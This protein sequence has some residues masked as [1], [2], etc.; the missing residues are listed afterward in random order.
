MSPRPVVMHID[1]RPWERW[2][3]E[4]RAQPGDA[5]WKTLISAGLTASRGLTL[6]VSELP[7][8]GVLPAHRHAQPEV[9]LVLDGTGVV[10]IQGSSTVVG[11]G[12]GLF[13][14]G[15]AVHSM[16]ST[17]ETPLR[18]AYVFAADAFEDVNYVFEE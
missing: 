7:P 12:C 17:G 4:Q 2:P 6:G 15:N 1:D 8:G 11:Q 3:A 10:T 13:I 14:P 16:E 18:V 5:R 9:Y